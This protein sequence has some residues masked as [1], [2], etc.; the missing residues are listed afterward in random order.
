MRIYFRDNDGVLGSTTVY[1]P[2]G[3]RVFL[4]IEAITSGMLYGKHTDVTVS[5]TSIYVTPY[6]SAGPRTLQTWFYSGSVN[7]LQNENNIYITRVEAWN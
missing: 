5:G 4:M 7:Y 6:D 3:K 1:K 2:N